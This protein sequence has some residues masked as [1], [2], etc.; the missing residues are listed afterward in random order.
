MIWQTYQLGYTR[1]HYAGVD[2][3][4]SYW[5]AESGAVVVTFSQSGL[6]GLSGLTGQSPMG[7]PHFAWPGWHGRW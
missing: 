5:T 1:R 6:T 7:R 2:Y 3:V 4:R